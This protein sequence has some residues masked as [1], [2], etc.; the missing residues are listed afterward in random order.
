MFLGA[1][2]VYRTIDT[3]VY[4][5]LPE[6]FLSIVNISSDADVAA[7]AYGAVFTTYG[8][9]TLA[10]LA[11]TAG[12]AA[13]AG[14][15][16]RGTIGLLLANPISR[17]GVVMSKAASMALLTAFGAVILWIAGRASPVVLD[18][19]TAGI[20]IEALLLHL[21]I[22]ALFYG[23]MAWAIGAW[24]GRRGLAAGVTA[25]VMVVSLVAVGIFPLI[26]GWENLARVFPWYYFT[27]SDPHLN[28]TNIGH[29]AV[30]AAGST[31]L[32]GLGL[33]GV[34]RRDLREKT[35]GTSLL[36]QLRANRFTGL[37]AERLAGG[38]WVRRIAPKTM[39]EFQGLTL[40]TSAL[41]F[42]VMGI[43]MGPMYTA[44]DTE[45]FEMTN[46]MPEALLALIGGEDM[47]TPEG[48]YQAETFSMMAPI[49]V[50]VVGAA[51][52]ARALAGEEANRTMGLLLA[53]PVSRTRVVLE[54]TAA[55]LALIVV[56]AA[57]TFAGVAGGSLL[58]D[59]GMDLG[60]V[61]ATS[62]LVAL[63]GFVFGSLA[64]LVSALTGRSGLA[65]YTSAGLALALYLIN[66]F[67]PLSDSLAGYARWS[68][69]YYYLGSN[70]LRNGMHWG[71][72]GLL[73]GLGV[74]MVGLAVVFFNRRD[75]RQG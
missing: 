22:N 75:L 53:N 69:F 41:M 40:I 57:A 2:A 17:T 47:S 11:I 15:E 3:S 9:L 28:G 54:K 45:L 59:L 14:E 56:V 42:F 32:V 72:G 33:I 19:S 34:N 49:A 4:T 31:A 50:I 8:A 39:S 66:A 70:P 27:G 24:T 35:A 73:A 68:P 23:F 10:G 12:S 71:H 38:T 5:S 25:A 37:V 55:M 64:L 21:L 30:L 58:S 61:A 62:A 48:F 1:M 60:P 13:I 20:H 18:V 7:L 65:T 29:L 52:G 26:E 46:D 63:I 67:F 16:R 51:V 44:I 36:D 43:L 74:A 6:A